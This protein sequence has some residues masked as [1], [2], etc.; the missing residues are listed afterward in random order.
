MEVP[1][2]MIGNIGHPNMFDII[3]FNNFQ[4]RKSHF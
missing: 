1:I 4:D 2:I 3:I